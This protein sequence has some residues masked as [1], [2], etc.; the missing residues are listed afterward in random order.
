M[1]L[2]KKIGKA[3][4]FKKNWLVSAAPMLRNQK[5]SVALNQTALSDASI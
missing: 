3:S 5:K 1:H 2:N 4:L